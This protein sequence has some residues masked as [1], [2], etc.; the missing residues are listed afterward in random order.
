[1]SY[2][3]V[4][5]LR[6]KPYLDQVATGTTNDA[7][8]QAVLDRANAIVNEALGFSFAAYGAVAT[9]K[10]VRGQG[11][12]WLRPPAYQA[13]SIMGITEVSGRGQS[14]ENETDVDDY[15]VDEDERPYRIYRND[16]WAR[17]AWYRVTAIWGYGAAPASVVEVEIEVASNIWRSAAVASFGT[18]VGVEGQGSVTVNR[19]LTWA[20]RSILDGV[21]VAYLGVVH[22]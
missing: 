22:A 11:D 17:N 4:A 10:D 9:D 15:L 7:A 3:T 1:M 12:Q 19:A 16:G 18:A 13:A 2:A 5:Q 6:A 8:L 21:R 14:D 20:Q